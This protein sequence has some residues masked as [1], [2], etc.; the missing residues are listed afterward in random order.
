[1]EIFAAD[2]GIVPT[3][4]LVAAVGPTPVAKNTNDAAT[5]TESPLVVDGVSVAVATPALSVNAKVE[6]LL[7]GANTDETVPFAA[8]VHDGVKVTLVP[9]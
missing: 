3:D 7:G 6:V 4:G 2:P 1:M 5:V 8:P 9:C